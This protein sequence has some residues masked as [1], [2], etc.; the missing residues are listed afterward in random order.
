M[1]P[2][3]VMRVASVGV[4]VRVKFEV[5]TRAKQAVHTHCGRDVRA[6]FASQIVKRYRCSQAQS[7]NVVCGGD[8]DVDRDLGRRGG[9]CGRCRAR[10]SESRMLPHRRGSG[11]ARG[12][13]MARYANWPSKGGLKRH[14]LA[15]RVGDYNGRESESNSHCVNHGRLVDASIVALGVRGSKRDGRG[16]RGDYKDS[17]R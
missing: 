14:A 3:R 5:A 2:K 17:S 8:A 9:W 11:C 1:C 7:K 10:C 4:E 16:G 12:N 6:E 15:G 13:P